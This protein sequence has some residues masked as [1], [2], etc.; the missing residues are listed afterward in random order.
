MQLPTPLHS[1]LC[2]AAFSPWEE[3]YPSSRL[4][5]ADYVQDVMGDDA[6]GEKIRE[7]ELREIYSTLLAGPSYWQVHP[8]TDHFQLFLSKEPAQKWLRRRVLALFPEVEFEKREQV[9]SLRWRIIPDL[10]TTN[11]GSGGISQYT[12]DAEAVCTLMDGRTLTAREGGPAHITQDDQRIMWV[13]VKIEAPHLLPLTY[14][15]AG[16]EMRNFILSSFG[17]PADVLR[18]NA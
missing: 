10:E 9:K 14:E 1:L 3:W 8:E 11:F 7:L 4:I 6:R 5:L 15:E 12:S 2:Q 18:G 16:E 17:V 13:T